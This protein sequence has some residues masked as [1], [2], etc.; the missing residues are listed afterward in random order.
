MYKN[1]ISWFGVCLTAAVVVFLRRWF[2]LSFWWLHISVSVDCFC[3]SYCTTLLQY[4]G[5]PCRLKFEISDYE[6]A[7]VNIALFTFFNGEPDGVYIE[8]FQK[9]SSCILT[10]KFLLPSVCW[11]YC[12]R[13]RNRDGTPYRKV[14]MFCTFAVIFCNVSVKTSEWTKYVNILYQIRRHNRYYVCT[15]LV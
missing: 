8:C 14:G 1:L 15:R 7:F 2:C 9:K 11:F 5:A 4:F 6:S 3:I 10:N 12:D 13:G